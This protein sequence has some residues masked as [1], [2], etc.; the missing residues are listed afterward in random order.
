MIS[1]IVCIVIY[2]YWTFC[3]YYVVDN[4][5][6]KIRNNYLKNYKLNE[7]GL[8]KIKNKHVLYNNICV[9]INWKRNC[10]KKTW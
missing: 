2:F 7:N 6:Q 4:L 1:L 5:K 10:K 8:E 3:K 9:V